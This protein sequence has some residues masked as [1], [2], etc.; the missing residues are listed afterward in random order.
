[1]FQKYADGVTKV[2][3]VNAILNGRV[4]EM[5]AAQARVPDLEQQIADLTAAAASAAT[6]SGSGDPPNV[7]EAVKAAVAA[8]ESQLNAE[9]AKQLEEARSAAGTTVVKD[10]PMDGTTAKPEHDATF[11]QRL[12]EAVSARTAELEK[13]RNDLKGKIEALEQKIKVLERNIRTTE[14]GRKL[15]EKQ[16]ESA[17]KK[18]DANTGDAGSEAPASPA[19]TTAVSAASTSTGQPTPGTAAPALSA[20]TPTFAPTAGTA[21]T[22][23]NP[24]ASNSA[25]STSAP[26]GPAAGTSTSVRGAGVRGRGRGA[27]R[28]ARGGKANSVLS[29]TFAMFTSPQVS[30]ILSPFSGSVCHPLGTCAEFDHSCE[31]YTC[32]KSTIHH[33]PC[34]FSHTDIPESQQTLPSHG[35]RRNIRRVPNRLGD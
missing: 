12:A 23:T 30:Y 1:M 18:G 9:H 5:T 13:E 6:T 22:S 24:A 16:L 34:S 33:D 15:A 25:P 31:C 20:A 10:E 27:G 11:D 4:R 26:T 32:P 8:R 19:P 2:N 17:L 14:I 28:G 35:G 29:G 21:S 7:E 3:R